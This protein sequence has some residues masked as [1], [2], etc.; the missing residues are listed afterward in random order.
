[1]AFV[2]INTVRGSKDE[3]PAVV[4][5]VQRL[6]LDVLRSQPGFRQARLLVAEDQTEASL[7]IEWESRDD[8]VAYRQTEAGRQLVAEAARL[9][10]HIAF[11]E[12]IAGFDRSGS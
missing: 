2:V 12:V 7:F 1:V 4:M 5:D 6:G 9:H 11:Y 8:F 3:I 10:P